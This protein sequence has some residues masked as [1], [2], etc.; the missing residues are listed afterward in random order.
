MSTTQSPIALAVSS[1]ELATCGVSTTL[2]S[3]ASARRHVRLV[4]EHVEPGGAE[5]SRRQRLGQRRLV[6]Q[7]AARD[8]DENAA[9]AE[10]LDDRPIDDRPPG[11]LRR[12]GGAEEQDV[13]V[14]R[15]RDGVGIGAIGDIARRRVDI[16]DVALERFEP[17]RHLDADPPE[18]DDAG[19]HAGELAPERQ[20]A[21]APAARTHEA[22]AFGKPAARGK[23]QADRQVGDV[24]V[25]HR[26]DRDDDAALTRRG[27]V[28][29]LE[30]DAVQRAYFEIRHQLDM[31]A[32]Q[33]GHAVAGRAADA[34]AER[35]QRRERIRHR[36]RR[37]AT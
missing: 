25:E 2:S 28:A 27:D 17:A 35:L 5:P 12:A 19:A 13:G 26:R 10:R 15:Q 8:V 22:V 33:A 31:G 18:P 21:G 30:P 7:P 4:V 36:H 3:A 16:A 24:V 32:G 9:R 20:A 37:D 1:V 14:P 11:S 29:G 34:R 23:R 6:D